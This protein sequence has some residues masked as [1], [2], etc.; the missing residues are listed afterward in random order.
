MADALSIATSGLIA[1]TK[2]INASASNVANMTTTGTIAG[3]TGSDPTAKSAYSPV[4]VQQTAAAGNTGGTTAVYTPI[5]PGWVAQYS[6]NDSSADGSG[7]VA[8]PDVDPVS[9]TVNQITAT[10]A[11]SASAAIVRTSDQMAQAL[12]DI[13]S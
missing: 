6:P 9:E 4:A 10:R 3:T 2:R 7:M 12:L 13:K 5:T 11:Y 8:A 1:Q